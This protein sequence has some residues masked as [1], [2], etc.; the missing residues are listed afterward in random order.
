MTYSHM[1][2]RHLKVFG[3]V[4][5]VRRLYLFVPMCAVAW[6]WCFHQRWGGRRVV[7]GVYRLLA[8]PFQR[9]KK[10][11]ASAE[12]AR[13]CASPAASPLANSWSIVKS[14][15]SQSKTH[16]TRRL[17]L[18][19]S[20]DPRHSLGQTRQLFSCVTFGKSRLSAL[21]STFSCPPSC[22]ENGQKPTVYLVVLCSSCKPRTTFQGDDQPNV[23]VVDDNDLS[24]V[25]HH[26]GRLT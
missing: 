13:C 4:F 1:Y 8:N 22:Q 7:G 16:H 19:R 25:R 24:V 23:V 11:T 9:K 10:T 5:F 3:D 18:G 14:I 12:K 6:T 26:A 15:V 20:T 2:K 21:V 17:P